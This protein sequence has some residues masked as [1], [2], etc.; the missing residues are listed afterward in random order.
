M[1]TNSEYPAATRKRMLQGPTSFLSSRWEWFE[2][3]SSLRRLTGIALLGILS[4]LLLFCTP[5]HSVIEG[6]LPNE[7]YH[8]EWVY[9]VPYKDASSQTVDSTRIN[10]N[11]FKITISDYNR[12][13]IGFVRLRPLLRLELQEIIV[14]TEQGT[15]QVRLDT[16]SSASGTPLNDVLQNWKDKKHHYDYEVYNLYLQRRIA[17]PADVEAIDK[18]IENAL[19]TYRNDVCLIISAN[20]NNDIGRFIFSLHQSFLTPEQVQ[21]LDIEN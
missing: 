12:D 3:Y 9:W 21:S 10:K 11:A 18:A 6:L 2:G 14:Y 4:F 15:T 19:T 17:E 20:K 5:P 8:D 7:N 1:T 13:K 16:I